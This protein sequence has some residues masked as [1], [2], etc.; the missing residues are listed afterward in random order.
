M[1]IIFLLFPF[2]SQGLWAAIPPHQVVEP[3]SYKVSL[4]VAM[5]GYA[6]ESFNTVAKS[7]KKSFISEFSSDG[8]SETLIEMFAKKSSFHNRQGLYL[9]LTFTKRFRGV[10]KASEHTQ[11]FVPENQELELNQGRGRHSA[12]NLSLAVVAHQL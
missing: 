7:G 5:N 3:H 8:Q 4:R 12:G 1:K 11:I 10:K 2:F 9:D 6:P